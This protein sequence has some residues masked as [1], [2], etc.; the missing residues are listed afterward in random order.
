MSLA[1]ARKSCLDANGVGEEAKG[2]VFFA[3]R[4]ASTGHE[5]EV[6]ALVFG[7]VVISSVAGGTGGKAGFGK[8]GAVVLR[9]VLFD[10]AI[11][12]IGDFFDY[13]VALCLAVFDDLEGVSTAEAAK[14][15]RGVVAEEKLILVGSDPSARIGG[16]RGGIKDADSATG[17]DNSVAGGS[18]GGPSSFWGGGSNWGD[19]FFD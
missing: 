12:A 2:G 19:G 17:D 15:G 11:I 4:L 9:A 1:W 10:V 7:F 3:D 5:N 18:G 8:I 13:F 16:K 14:D 6:V